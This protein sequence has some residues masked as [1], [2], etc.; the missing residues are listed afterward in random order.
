MRLNP[1]LRKKDSISFD[2]ISNNLEMLETGVNNIKIFAIS[3]S[4]S[5]PDFYE[6][7]FI[8]TESKTELPA[9]TY[10][11]IEFSENRQ[12]YWIWVIPAIVIIGILAYLKLKN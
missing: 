11:N 10:K 8:V 7:S 3:N 1:I 4:V 12:E 9:S 5:K 6:S 2:V